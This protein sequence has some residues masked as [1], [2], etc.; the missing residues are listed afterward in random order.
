MVKS[1]SSRFLRPALCDDRGELAYRVAGRPRDQGVER[2]RI[3]EDALD[4]RRKFLET[5]ADNRI[6]CD[7]EEIGEAPVDRQEAAIGRDQDHPFARGV[8]DGARLALRLLGQP[9]LRF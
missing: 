2:D 3:G 5:P 1:E 9:V 8:D 6:E 7:I 4:Q